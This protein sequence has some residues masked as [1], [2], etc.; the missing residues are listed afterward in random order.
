MKEP[1]QVREDADVAIGNGPHAIDKVGSGEVQAFFRDFW[2]LES[3]QGFGFC[4]QIGFN[5]SGACGCSRSH[6]SFS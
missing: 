1:V 5:F 2:G 3:Q 4:S 6:F